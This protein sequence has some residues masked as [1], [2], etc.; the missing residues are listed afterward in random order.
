MS[1]SD[2][3]RPALV[4]PAPILLV[5]VLLALSGASVH[6][7]TP[8]TPQT[9]EAHVTGKTITYQQFGQVFGV[10]EYLENR[11]VRWSVAPGLCQYGIWYP[12][13]DDICF[14]YEDD[15]TASCWTFWLK[16]G[17]LV[18]LSTDDAPGNE[19]YETD[20]TTQGLDCPG[21]DVGV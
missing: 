6:A 17:A 12:D 18:A 11:A 15:P 10:E 13:G 8:V 2:P 16:D 14:L 4:L 5:P 21:P 9:F 19:L 3:V 20:R 7:E 1:A